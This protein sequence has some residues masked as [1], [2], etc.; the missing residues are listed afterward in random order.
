MPAYQNDK[1]DVVNVENGVC[2]C[3]C[4]LFLHLVTKCFIH[5]VKDVFMIQ[6][7]GLDHIA[8]LYY[9]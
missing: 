2:V 1:P 7:R 6:A 4:S 5:I 3:V 8:R 9:Q